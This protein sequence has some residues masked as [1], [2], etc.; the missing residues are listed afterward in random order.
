MPEL[1]II[2]PMSDYSWVEKT[3]F[4]GLL[5]API[6]VLGVWLFWIQFSEHPT[7]WLL[8]ASLAALVWLIF[9]YE[10]YTYG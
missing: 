10:A 5:A 8:P 7:F 6:I 3:A 2:E 4:L 9:A 1:E